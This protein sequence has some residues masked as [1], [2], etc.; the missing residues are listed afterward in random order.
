MDDQE[1][2]DVGRG[3]AIQMLLAHAI[4]I[5]WRGR[6]DPRGAVRDVLM[7]MEEEIASQCERAMGDFLHADSIEVAS[8]SARATILSVGRLTDS[9]L[10][11]MGAPPA[12]S[13]AP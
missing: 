4:A 1:L 8:A 6:P 11:A 12:D 2:R 7:A 5:A 10:I 13:I 9:F 3:V